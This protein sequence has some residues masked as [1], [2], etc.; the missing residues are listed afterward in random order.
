MTR[1]FSQPP[2]SMTL[3][4]MLLW[5][6]RS[7]ADALSDLSGAEAWQELDRL[8]TEMKKRLKTESELHIWNR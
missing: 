8:I 4:Q 3:W 7:I 2:C 6:Y 5:H 1:K